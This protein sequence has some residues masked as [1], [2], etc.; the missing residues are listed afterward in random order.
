LSGIETTIDRKTNLGAFLIVVTGL[1]AE[2]RIA[3]TSGVTVF[4]CG[5]QVGLKAD[6]IRQAALSG[7]AGIVSFGIA[8]GLDPRLKAGDWV[9]ATG[10]VS[11]GRSIKTDSEWSQRLAQR[12]PDAELGDIA[13]VVDPVLD[14]THKRRLQAA[15]GAMAVDMES[16]HAA[17]LAEE[18]G[19]PFAAA[20]VIADPMHREVP[21]AARLGLRSDGSLAVAPILRS[22]LG[23]PTQL[24]GLLRVT[25]D[26]AIA[27]QALLRGRPELGPHFASV[28]CP[29]VLASDPADSE[30]DWRQATPVA[31]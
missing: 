28:T 6:A 10:V 9:I 14:P 20:R 18:L 21:A 7:V 4:A 31:A 22:L 2:A 24:P 19:V 25:R 11:D 5:G 30:P 12:I 29:T 13:S 23:K 1:E 3:A 17:A 8:G 15:T 16:F 26:V 27:F